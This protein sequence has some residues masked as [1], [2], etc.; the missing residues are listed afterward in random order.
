MG[1]LEEH[2]LSYIEVRTEELVYGGL[3][4][5][6]HLMYMV[7]VCACMCMCVYGGIWV[8]CARVCV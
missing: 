3:P 7:C 6:E 8:C 4:L 1:G 2:L 5:P